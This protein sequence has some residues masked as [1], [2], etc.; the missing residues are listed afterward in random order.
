MNL[1]PDP[2]PFYLASGGTSLFAWL[3]RSRPKEVS[4][5]GLVIC[6]PFGFEEVCAHRSLRHLAMAAAEAGIPAM[7]F[8]YAGC[9]N[10][11]G[12]DFLPDRLAEWVKS[13]HRAADAL[14]QMTGVTSICLAGLRLGATLATL[15]AL[16][17]DDVSGLVAIAPILRGRNYLRELTMLGIT[18]AAPVPPEAGPAD[19]ALLESAGFLLTRETSEALGTVDLRRLPKAPAARVLIVDRDDMPGA[20]PWQADLERVGA[21]AEMATWPGYAAMMRDPQRSR[22][23]QPIIDGV[24][25]WLQRGLAPAEPMHARTSEAATDVQRIRVGER[26]LLE[27]VLHID[28]GLSPLFGVLTRE[29]GAAAARPAVL[30]LNSGSV[31]NIGPNRLWVQLARRWAFQ[32]LTVLRLDISGIGDSPACAGAEENVVYTPHAGADI[33]AALAYLRREVGATECHVMGLCSG[34]YHALKAAMA[35]QYMASAL[36]INPLTFNWKEGSDMS[37]LKDYEVSGLAVKFRRQLFTA[38]PW[39]KLL[40]RKVNLRI[41][42]KVAWLRLWS[43]VYPHMLELARALHIPFKHDLAR[44]LAGVAKREIRLKFVF[45]QDAPG[46]E[47]LEREGGRAVHRMVRRHQ[48]TLD[49][50]PGA[51][52]TFTRLA[53]RERLVALLDERV[54]AECTRS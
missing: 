31:H 11:E 41:V 20:G 34:G 42:A 53:A 29:E 2:Q 22:V 44:E 33:A 40:R 38:T 18:G 24:V 15:A 47:L 51:D 30:M 4:A 26:T 6:N 37:E 5:T 10:S 48:A 54:L 36:M 7:R 43:F 1:L 8:D 12:D 16:Q 28:T 52:H 13:I 25:E 19:G 9:G 17:R 35:G 50:V 3:H 32:G 23:P 39:K 14:K 21:Q 45:A 49:F 27:R 46:F